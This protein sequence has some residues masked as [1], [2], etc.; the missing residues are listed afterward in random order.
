MRK[1]FTLFLLLIPLWMQAQ[2]DDIWDEESKTLTV[3]LGETT[4]YSSY[5]DQTSGDKGGDEYG[6]WV[7][8]FYGMEAITKRNYLR[9]SDEYRKI[10]FFWLPVIERDNYTEKCDEYRKICFF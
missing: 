10:C 6:D 3:T 5:K 1:I 9:R 7:D 2:D 4:E 8:G